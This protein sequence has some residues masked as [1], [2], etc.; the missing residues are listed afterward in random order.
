M[1]RYDVLLFDLDDT[2][3]DF[4][5]AEK[6]ALKRAFEGVGYAYD[7]EK[8][9]PLY[10]HHNRASWAAFEAG[11]IDLETLKTGRFQKFC[12]AV[13]PALDPDL[14]RRFFVMYL[15]ESAHSIAGAAR[16]VQALSKQ[17][18]LA[19]ITNGLKDVQRARLKRWELAVHF[20]VVVISDEIGAKKPDPE[21]F[22]HTL[23][24][25]GYP[26]KERCLIIGDSLTSD[27]QGGAN[28]GIETCWFNPGGKSRGNGPAP[29]YEIQELRE[30]LDLLFVP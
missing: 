13:S 14:F 12:D 4:A 1:A 10:Q 9:L 26:D 7:E 27:I 16:V 22:D 11:T 8:H 2:L 30:L 24:S 28:A 19:L 25:L 5:I 29:T 6:S 18:R 21:F 15:G 17:Y 23:R 3:L 20:P